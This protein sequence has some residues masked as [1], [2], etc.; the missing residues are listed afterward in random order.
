MPKPKPNR[1]QNRHRLAITCALGGVAPI[2]Q[3]P[4]GRT[5]TTDNG[6]RTPDN[7]PS[8]PGVI[9]N[10]FKLVKTSEQV[11]RV[12]WQEGGSGKSAEASKAEGATTTYRLSLLAGPV[13]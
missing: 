3:W 13:T 11:A 10:E 8:A 7:L 4:T 1:M 2:W 9:I 12:E 6:Q 5:S